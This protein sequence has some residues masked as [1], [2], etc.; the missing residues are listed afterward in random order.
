[1]LILYQCNTYIHITYNYID[2]YIHQHIH[3]Q[4]IHIQY[5]YTVHTHTHTQYIPMHIW[6]MHALISY[7]IP[8]QIV[9]Q[10]IV[11]PIICT[12][13]Y[14]PCSIC[15]HLI[16]T[17]PYMY[18]LIYIPLLYT[19]AYIYRIYIAYCIIYG[20]YMCPRFIYTL[21]IARLYITTPHICH[22]QDVYKYIYM[23]GINRP[24]II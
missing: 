20:C 21:V 13:L 16:Q 2:T 1:M 7:S 9:S 6:Y 10:Q 18:H 15:Y 22:T 14:S 4:T 19:H 3:T 17:V 8:I 24:I 11:Y 12:C 23:Q 5:M